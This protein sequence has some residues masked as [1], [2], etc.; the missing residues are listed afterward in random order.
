MV[1]LKALHAMPRNED[2]YPASNGAERFWKIIARQ[3]LA[4]PFILEMCFWWAWLRRETRVRR[5]E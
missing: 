4:D 2:S 1:L 3:Q 5:T